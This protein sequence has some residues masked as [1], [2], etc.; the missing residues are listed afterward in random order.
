ME[1]CPFKIFPMKIMSA[2]KLLYRREYIHETLYK[3]KLQSDDMQR[4]KQEP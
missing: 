2:L 3:Y 4:K 1:L